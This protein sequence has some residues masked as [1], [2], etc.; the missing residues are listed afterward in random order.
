[1]GSIRIAGLIDKGY[2]CDSGKEH[3][4]R[5][6]GCEGEL[7][8]AA[9]VHRIVFCTNLNKDILNIG[10]SRDPRTKARSFR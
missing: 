3:E 6:D 2:D 1:M 4:E 7:L 5:I 9:V 8:W 10:R